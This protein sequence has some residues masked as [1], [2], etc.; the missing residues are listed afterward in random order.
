MRDRQ[1]GAVGK[2]EVYVSGNR[3]SLGDSHFALRDIPAS[4]KRRGVGSDHGAQLFGHCVAVG[5]NITLVAPYCAPFRVEDLVT[6]GSVG[7]RRDGVAGA[8]GIVVPSVEALSGLCRSRRKIQRCRFDRVV[9]RHE[10]LI[11]NRR[12]GVRH[13]GDG[14]DNRRPL[15]IVRLVLR[16]GRG[17]R[18]HRIAGAFLVGIPAGELVAGWRACRGR[19]RC[20]RTGRVLR[21]LK[22]RQLRLTVAAV[23]VRN[24]LGRIGNRQC[25]GE[26]LVLRFRA[27]A[28]IRHREHDSLGSRRRRRAANDA[29][30]ELEA[31]GKRSR[32]LH[33]RIGRS[34]AAHRRGKRLFKRLADDRRKSIHRLRQRR[35]T[36]L[37]DVII[38]VY[39][40]QRDQG[41]AT[42][43]LDIGVR[44]RRARTGLYDDVGANSQSALGNGGRAAAD[45]R[46]VCSAGS[47]H[48][49]TVDGDGSA[50]AGNLSAA[51]AANASSA[52]TG[53]CDSSAVDRDRAASN[54]LATAIVS[55]A[56]SG[57][58]AGRSRGHRAAV[59]RD[60]AACRRRETAAN[61]RTD[62]SSSRLKNTRPKGLAVNSQRILARDIDCRIIRPRRVDGKM[63]SICKD[64]VYAAGNS[65][66][67]IDRHIPIHDIPAGRQ[68]RSVRG[69]FRA[70]L[71]GHCVAAG[72]DITLVA[73]YDAPLRVEDLVAGGAVRDCRNGVACAGGI[74]VPSVKAL[75]YVCRSRRKIQRCRFDC[76]VRRHEPLVRNRRRGVLHVGDGIDDRRPLRIVRLVLRLEGGNSSHCIAGAFLGSVP[77]GELV[78]VGRAC[79]GRKRGRHSGQVLRRLKIRQ[80]RRSIA[81]VDVR[82]RLGRIGNRHGIGEVLTQVVFANAGIRHR[83]DDGFGSRRR[84]R[85]GNDAVVELEA[86]WKRSRF[87]NKRVGRR[88]AAYRRGKSLFKR[89]ADDRRKSIRRLDETRRADSL[90][91]EVTLPVH[92]D[93]AG[94]FIA[95][96][97]RCGTGISAR[98]DG[99]GGGNGQGAFDGT[100]P[101]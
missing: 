24:R 39:R 73:P 27:R 61:C 88:A 77:A 43:I 93:C 49:A 101:Q 53:G 95:I 52:R 20:C 71:F 94:R 87:L 57:A 97:L 55:T 26:V 7:D 32:L 98:H 62:G 34:A 100:S 46:L 3:N 31:G 64:E 37:L 6:G 48:R 12:R 74:V 50:S 63:G 14:I 25:I 76:V 85:A 8:G 30:V 66:S 84:R 59:D 38:L 41:L 67:R 35:G 4:R 23:D 10:T 80:L 96:L 13:V 75:S 72:I 91:E 79:R 86:G 29:V 44:Q 18:R 70:Q 89:L 17:N 5:I 36:L 33:E 78:A 58:A 54:T 42:G 60:C 51:T 15:R 83:E 1:R 81:A 22:S 9:R 45:A 40:S 69:D 99:H 68:R 47:C 21:R 19:K 92:G 11:R 65:D 56:D 90:D 2:N 16:L 82:N 28:G